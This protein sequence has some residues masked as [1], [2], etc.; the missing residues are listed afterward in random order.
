MTEV[1]VNAAAGRKQ[2]RRLETFLDVAYAVLFVDF[3]MYLPHTEDMAWT[4]LP[5]G[6][7]SLL[8]DDSANLLRLIIAVGLTLISWNL[9]HKLLG[10]LDRTNARHTLLALLQ[11]IFVCLFLFFAIADPELESLSSP[12]GQSLSLALSGFIGIAGWS[13]ARKN[14]LVRADLSETEKD[15]VPRNAI[16]EPVT[17]LLNT[18]FAFVGPAAWTAGWFVIPM[19]LVTGR[20]RLERRRERA[21]VGE[22]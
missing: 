16:V 2:L 13:Y 3:I 4:E 8:I 6:L 9:T 19:V 15:D 1:D 14:G 21:R 5:Y 17:A 7:L 11:L 20:G 12:V 18:G 22:R 10:P